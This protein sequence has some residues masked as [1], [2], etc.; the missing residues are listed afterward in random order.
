M[1]HLTNI[2]CWIHFVG[3]KFKDVGNLSRRSRKRRTATDWR[4]KTCRFLCSWKSTA[5]QSCLSHVIPGQPVSCQFIGTPWGPFVQTV[6]FA[7]NH[8]ICLS[9]ARCLDGHTNVFDSTYTGRTTK[10]MNQPSSL[11]L[12]RSND[13]I[14]MT[15]VNIK[16]QTGSSD[17]GLF[18]IANATAICCGVDPTLRLGSTSH[19]AASHEMFQGWLH[20]DGSTSPDVSRL[21]TW[22]WFHLTRCFKAGYMEMVP[23]HQMFQGWL[24]GDGSTSPDVSRLVTWR[25]FHLT[26]CFKAGYMEMVPPHQMFQGWLHGDGSTS[27]D[28]S[29]L[30]TWRWFQQLPQE[31]LKRLVW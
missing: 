22:R 5:N 3:A 2:I 7:G 14:T 25:W 20:R 28:V 8:W 4:S 26:R 30:V 11:L 29:R 9:N 21:V 23:P 18:T 15:W 27:P 24:H 1:L 16:K 12:Y 17:C 6:N 19:D 10:L 13:M 31:N